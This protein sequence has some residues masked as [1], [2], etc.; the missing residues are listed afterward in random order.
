MSNTCNKRKNRMICFFLAVVT[1]PINAKVNEPRDSIKVIENFE[2]SFRSGRTVYATI[3]ERMILHRVPGASIAVIKN[4]KL[5]FA[6]G[7]GVKQAGSNNMVDTETVF[8]VGSISK[9][10]AA[11]ATLRL[12]E[13]GKLD[14]DTDVNQ[15][16]SSWKV[17]ENKYTKKQPVTLRHILSHTAGFTIHGFGD[18]QPEE[19]LPSIL[20]TLMGR[21]PAKHSAVEVVFTPGTNYRYS[22]GGITVEQLV[23]EETTKLD[24]V[25][26]AKKLVFE[27]L[28]MK[29]STFRNPLPASHENIAKAHG[30]NGELR[31]LPRGWESMPEMAAS[32]LWTTPTEI[33]MLIVAL[34][35][36]YKGERSSIL[37]TILAKDMMTR[38]GPGEFGLGPELLQANLFQHGGSNDSY[39]AFMLA[40]LIT[41][42]GIVVF[43]NSANGRPL[44]D[45]IIESIKL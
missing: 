26:A 12:V 15:Y 44:V 24:F 9:V 13:H 39:R 38:V 28:N 4:G 18:F 30:S 37:G 8:S 19:E 6:K 29:R 20:D 45:E 1:L 14:L 42:N 23:I 41:G 3:E 43:T 31:A 21:P 5:A 11:V 32:G 16:L 17:A 33:A 10:A 7:Y 25:T 34:I 22:G 2:N 36:A 35:D 40:N 27:P